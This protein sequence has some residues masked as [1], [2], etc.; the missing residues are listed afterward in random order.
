M[1]VLLVL[2]LTLILFLVRRAVFIIT[3]VVAIVCGKFSKVSALASFLYRADVCKYDRY[4]REAENAR[5]K[6]QQDQQHEV[7]WSSPR[8][9][10]R[11]V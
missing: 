5:E 6:H 11:P 1:G 8:H 2:T 4:L 10:P 9:P 3:G 7:S